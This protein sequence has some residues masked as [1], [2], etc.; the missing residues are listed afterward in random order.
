MIDNT[1][2]A[3]TNTLIEYSYKEALDILKDEIEKIL[4]TSPKIIREYTMHLGKSFG[5]LM[6]AKSILIC[7]ENEQGLVHRNA[8]TLATAIELLHLATLVHDDVIDRSDMRRGKVTL[9]KK[10]GNRT[11]VICGDYLLSVALKMVASVSDKEKYLDKKIPDFVGNICLGELRQQ[12]NNGNY[13]LSVFQYLRII[14]GKT[15]CMFK[16]AF[17]AGASLVEDD[18]TIIRQYAKIGHYLGMIFQLTDD[19]MDFETTEVVAKK[20]VQSDYE[21]DVI[22]LPLIHTFKVFGNAREKARKHILSKAEINKLVEKSGGLL[23]TRKLARKYHRKAIKLIQ[24]L[25]ISEQKRVKMVSLLDNA[26]RVF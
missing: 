19:C 23:Y 4:S 20:P 21:K 22:T 25:E 10:Y 18:E 13:N 7:A 9:Q 5:K 14:S 17:Y 12:I 1:K 6:R 16:T 8:V 2:Q 26:Y 3:D 24:E 15:A 11:A